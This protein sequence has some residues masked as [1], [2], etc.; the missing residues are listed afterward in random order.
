[1]YLD[2]YAY[3]FVCTIMHQRQRRGG[4]V[5]RKAWPTRRFTLGLI[6]I[7]RNE[8]LTMEKELQLGK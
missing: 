7:T 1:M 3:I 2:Q 6:N 8:R 4:G 5:A